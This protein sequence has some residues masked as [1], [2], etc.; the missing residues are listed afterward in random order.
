LIWLNLDEAIY[1]KNYQ[2]IKEI[3]NNN[4]LE[5]SAEEIKNN[6]YNTFLIIFINS[7]KTGKVEIELNKS[8]FSKLSFDLVPSPEDIQYLIK[9]GILK[10]WYN[11]DGVKINI[12]SDQPIKIKKILFV[13][14]HK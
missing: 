4:Q 1:S 11:Q 2:V 8:A 12:K 3:S 13:K 5:L 14:E 7:E 9:P 10:E 6:P